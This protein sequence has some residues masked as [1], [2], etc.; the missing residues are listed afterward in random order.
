MSSH[1]AS[2][3]APGPAQIAAVPAPTRYL[4]P[5]GRALFAALFLFA[6][7]GHFSAPTI[8]YA[9]QQ[10]VPLPG[11]L[12]PASGVLALVGGLS[13]L[14]GYRA[15]LGSVLV[16][17][18]LIPVTLSMHRF[19]GETDPMAAQLHLVMFLKNLAVLGGALLFAHYGAGPV[20]FD[21]RS[22]TATGAR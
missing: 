12:V 17:L 15:R 8:A 10:G 9:A 20:S 3:A 4:V 2:V 18:F 5:V 11:L 13:I 1:V 14:L 16:A 6:A 21:A 22:H 19:W 7:T